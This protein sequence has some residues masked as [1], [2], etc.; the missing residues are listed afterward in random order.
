MKRVVV[1]AENLFMSDISPFELFDIEPVYTLDWDEVESKK[2]LFQKMLHPDLFPIGSSEYEVAREKLSSANHA[3][4]LLKDP[5]QRAK[6]LFCVKNIAIPG[7]NGK[8]IN[9]PKMMEEALAL[10]EL[11]EE[12]TFNNNFENLFD[13]L[14][15]K[16]NILENAFNKAFLEN[17]ITE[18]KETYIRLSFCIKTLNDAHAFCFRNM[19]N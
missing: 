1:D 10:K 15:K 7:E 6:A 4:T 18:M 13:V 2:S 16:Q 14:N 19:G 5:I 17:N 8:T 12:A 11:L 3:Y 9:D